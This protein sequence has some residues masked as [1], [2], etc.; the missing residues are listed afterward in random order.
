[1]IYCMSD[2]HGNFKK[3]Q[4]MLKLLQLKEADTLYILGDVVDR[5]GQSMEILMDMMCRLN[6]IPLLGNHEFMAAKML[7]LLTREV[8]EENLHILNNDFMQ[9]MLEWMENGG[10]ATMESYKRLDYEEKLDILDFL[11]DFSLYEEVR[12]KGQNYVLVHAGL[13][14]FAPN[15][16]L[17]DYKLHELIF[18]RANYEIPYF[19]DKIVITGHT[20][21]RYIPENAGKDCIYK[22]NNHIAIDCGAWFEDGRLGAICLDTME[23][24]YV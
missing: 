18:E 17:Q 4:A 6:V 1:M 8:T 10:Q 16:P 12:V 2:I 11:A 15:K 3:Y 23:E 24:F 9:G 13:A 5:G 20:P 14:N 7:K 19:Q 21:T 22:G